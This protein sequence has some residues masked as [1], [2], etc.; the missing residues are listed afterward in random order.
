MSRKARTVFAARYPVHVTLRC[1]A[2]VGLCRWDVMELACTV[3]S[4]AHTSSF[5][6]CELNLEPNHV[7]LILEASGREDLADGLRRFQRIFARR[8]NGLLGRS[9]QVFLDRYYASLLTTPTQVRNAIRYVLNNRRHHAAGANRRLPDGWFDPF[10][11]AAW[12][13][14][15]DVPLQATT[16]EQRQAV[17]LHRPTAPPQTWLLAV[18]W[19]RLGLLS[20]DEIP[21]DTR[22]LERH[23][24]ELAHQFRRLEID[25]EWRVMRGE[26]L[27]LDDQP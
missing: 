18:G 5:R 14:G 3:I 11:S 20:P 15:W 4:E 21:G 7:H 13:S 16:Q 1:V 24:A 12:F 2:G 10:S 25:Y 8:L 23:E 9:G 22:A 19:R 17:A 26:L 27:V 6:I